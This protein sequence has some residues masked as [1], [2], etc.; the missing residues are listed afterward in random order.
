MAQKNNLTRN[1]SG[2]YL[3]NLGWKRS[4]TGYTQHK[5][6]L[7]R[8]ETAATMVSQRLEELW[9]QVEA[10]WERESKS[11][12]ATNTADSGTMNLE[13]TSSGHAVVVISGLPQTEREDRPVWDATSLAIAEAIRSGK[14]VAHVELPAYLKA[15]LPESPFIGL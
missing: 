13:T 3:R 1:A 7:G 11:L 12:P 15:Q 14:P 5:F 6:Y 8:D 10:R 2:L 4:R 9:S